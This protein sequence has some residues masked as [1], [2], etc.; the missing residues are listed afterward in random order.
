MKA[1]ELSREKLVKLC[2]SFDGVWILEEN[3]DKAAKELLK[4]FKEN[5]EDSLKELE[6]LTT[7]QQTK[8]VTST[9]TN[10]IY[11]PLKN[12]NCILSKCAAYTTHNEPDILKCDSCGDT[13]YRGQRCKNYIKGKPD[14]IKMSLYKNMAYC[15]HFKCHVFI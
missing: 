1:L 5:N 6:L 11:C 2:M 14:H 15:K 10:L 3:L 9:N 7:T 12:S 4:I 8:T 13:F